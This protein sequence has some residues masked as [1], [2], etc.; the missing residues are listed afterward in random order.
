M[1]YLIKRV[2][3]Q[4]SK[5]LILGWLRSILPVTLIDRFVVGRSISMVKGRLNDHEEQ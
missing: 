4:L 1:N 2:A 5:R 3:K